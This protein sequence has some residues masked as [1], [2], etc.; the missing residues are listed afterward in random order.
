LIEHAD[1]LVENLRPGV[2]GRLGLGFEQLARIGMADRLDALLQA[3][4]ITITQVPAIPS[5]A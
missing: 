5:S 4:A 1:V 2:M 3:G